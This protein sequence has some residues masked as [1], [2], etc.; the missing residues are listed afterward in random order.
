MDGYG[1]RHYSKLEQ[2]LNYT[3]GGVVLSGL[4]I[5]P[6]FLTATRFLAM[7]FLKKGNLEDIFKKRSNVC[8]DSSFLSSLSRSSN[9][10][11]FRWESRPPLSGCHR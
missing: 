2:W 7:N 4:W 10:S 9:T 1:P 6:F 3:I 8:L 5:G 11:S